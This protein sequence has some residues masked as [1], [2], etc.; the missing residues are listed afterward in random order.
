MEKFKLM[1]GLGNMEVVDSEGKGG[2]LAV[3]WRR[4]VNVVVRNSSK[5]HI[6]MD[7][8]DEDDFTWR[9]TGMYG[10][11][12]VELKHRTWSLMRDRHAMRELMWLCA[13]DFNEV[14][15]QHEKEGGESALTSVHGSV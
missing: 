11:S 14:L 12:Q 8:T 6:D 15:H 7:V 4:G 1:F 13:G 5:N 10:E 9:F 2:G 3:L